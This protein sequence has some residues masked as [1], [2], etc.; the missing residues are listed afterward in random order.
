MLRTQVWSPNYANCSKYRRSFSSLPK[1]LRLAEL[2]NKLM[3]KQKVPRNCDSLISLNVIGLAGIFLVLRRLRSDTVKRTRTNAFCKANNDSVFLHGST[4]SNGSPRRIRMK[5]IY[6]IMPN[7]VKSSKLICVATEKFKAPTNL[8][9]HF[10]ICKFNQ[11]QGKKGVFG[12]EKRI[13]LALAT[14]HHR[15]EME[16]YTFNYLMELIVIF[17]LKMCFFIKGFTINSL[18]LN[19]INLSIYSDLKSFFSKK[20]R[21]F[22]YSY[23]NKTLKSNY[24]LS[25]RVLLDTQLPPEKVRYSAKEILKRE[26]LKSIIF[27]LCLRLSKLLQFNRKQR[28][29]LL[30]FYVQNSYCWKKEIREKK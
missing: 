17:P 26:A 6:K 3:C 18:L 1:V 4:Q 29:F 8:D 14:I 22:N 19:P 16:F 23:S 5:V 2:F 27:L 9:I 10:H 7:R 11:A 21:V 30:A 13:T 28:S 15:F 12:R 24:F 25:E 20:R